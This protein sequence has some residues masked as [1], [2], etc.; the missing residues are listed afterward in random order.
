MIYLDYNIVLIY[1]LFT[2][3]EIEIIVYKCDLSG[4]GNI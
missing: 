4:I 2:E 1:Q 3:S